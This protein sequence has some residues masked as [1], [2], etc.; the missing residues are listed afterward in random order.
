MMVHCIM[1]ERKPRCHDICCLAL[2]IFF[3]F[4]MSWE[5]FPNGSIPQVPWS[6]GGPATCLRRSH[7][8]MVLSQVFS[9]GRDHNSFFSSLRL[10]TCWYP[11]VFLFHAKDV[12]SQDVMER[13]YAFLTIIGTSH[14]WKSDGAVWILFVEIILMI[15]AIGIQQLYPI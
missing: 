13:S 9:Y 14:L 8:K 4:L 5:L 6:L 12:W 11:A 2:V 15:M 10:F 3:F 1:P 7:F